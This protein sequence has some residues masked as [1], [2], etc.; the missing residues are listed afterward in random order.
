MTTILSCSHK[1]FITK[2]LKFDI[3]KV[4][5]QSPITHLFLNYETVTLTASAFIDCLYL[6]QIQYKIQMYSSFLWFA[7][8]Q[9]TFLQRGSN[10]HKYFYALKKHTHLVQN[11]NLCPII[12]EAN[13]CNH[14]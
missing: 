8:P 2:S 5:V 6:T 9:M 3:M 13:I 10:S 12:K 7:K 1:L 4:L 11:A 14:F